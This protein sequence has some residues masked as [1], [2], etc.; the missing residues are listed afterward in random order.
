[1]SRRT[2]LKTSA[3][4]GVAAAIPGVPYVR[5]STHD[6]ERTEY[7]ES[8]QRLNDPAKWHNWSG[9]ESATP[10]AI[11]VPENEAELADLLAN[12]GGKI[13]P[14]GTGHS[15]T[16]LVPTNGKIVDLAKFAGL[17]ETDPEQMTARIWAGTR[18]RRGAGLLA[19]KGLGLHN[20]PD[21]DV[22][23]FAGSF[24]T[25]THGTGANLP[26]IHDHVIGMRLVTPSG[27][28]RDLTATNDPDLFAA[29]KVS[30]GA[31]G[32]ITQYTLQLRENYNLNRKLYIRPM[33]DIFD[34]AEEKFSAHRHYEFFYGPSSPLG[35]EVVHD[36][37]QGE[38]YGLTETEDSNELLDALEGIR[39]HLGWFPWLRR[40]TV[41]ALFP[42][43]E[44]EDVGDQYWRML[45]SSRPFKFNEMEYHLPAEDGIKAAREIAVILDSNPNNFYPMEVRKIAEDDAWLSPFNGGPRV[46]IAVHAA[47]TESYAHFFKDIEPVFQKYGGR[48]HWGK[49]HSLTAT[50]LKALYPRFDDFIA[51]RQEL[52]PTGRMLNPHLSALFEDQTS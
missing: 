25:A 50:D 39:N 37:Y 21:I 18:L 3:A 13:R 34:G 20:L 52:D 5:W 15:F 45:T 8:A 46:S 27:D 40:Q 22:Q 30:L 17:V 44:M 51:L 41:N 24:S 38:P 7:Q 16:G 33:A 47:H 11:T 14:V 9:V 12:G 29:A 6:R 48:P 1:M 2:V 4:V 28:V 42:Q 43:G 19:E 35:L 23:T 31:L 49:L 26:A 32:I 10:E 36:E